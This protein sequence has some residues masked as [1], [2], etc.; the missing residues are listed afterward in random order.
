MAHQF[1]PNFV[2]EEMFKNLLIVIVL[3][4]EKPETIVESFVEWICFINTSLMTKFSDLEVGLRNEAQENFEKSIVR[5][6]LIFANPNE[7]EVLDPAVLME[8]M[9]MDSFLG[10]PLMIVANKSD[11]LLNLSEA[12]SNYVQFTL[13]SLAVKYGASLIFTSP[14]Q[15]INLKTLYNYLAYIM[16]H[17]DT[18]L[19]KVDLLKAHEVFIPMG[20]DNQEHLDQEFA[21]FKNSS[22]KKKKA[23]ANETA[24]VVEEVE[25]IVEPAEFFKNLK[26][27]KLIYFNPEKDGLGEQIQ[28]RGTM[29]TR[30]SIFEQPKNRI[31]EVIGGKK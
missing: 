9:D 29:N 10:L 12:D 18:V 30:R 13:R 31:L 4:L 22:L 28:R 17:N 24:Q 16:L 7:N 8:N 11:A 19:P 3:D 21:E 6:K 26:E 14:K 2:T 5:N 20:F 23:A 27:N 15:N 25:E 1:F